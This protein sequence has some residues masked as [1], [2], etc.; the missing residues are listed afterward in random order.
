MSTVVLDYLD[1]AYRR[2]CRVVGSDGS[3]EWRWDQQC[4]VVLRPG[5]APDRRPAPSDV[6]PTYHRQ[7]EAFL[8]AVAAGGI[9]TRSPLCDAYAGAHSVAQIAD[10]ARRSAADGGRRTPVVTNAVAAQRSW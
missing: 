3:V 10:A 8:D 5:H 1:R 4:V 7:I 6:V 2:G 9:P